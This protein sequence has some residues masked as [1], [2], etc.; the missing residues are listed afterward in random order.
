METVSPSWLVLKTGKTNSLI[1]HRLGRNF[2][3]IYKSTKDNKLRQFLF[4]L[5]YRIIMT[6]E[7]LFKFRLL[8]DEECTLCFR[9]DSIE[10]AFL[11][12]TVTTAFYS[13][14]ISWFNQENDTDITLSNKLIP[15][16]DIPRLIHLTD[17]PR[18]RLHLFV[19]IL[20]E[21]FYTSKCLEK[22]PNTLYYNGKE[23]NA[24]FPKLKISPRSLFFLI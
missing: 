8:E 1:F 4:R 3:F 12:C 10:H 7:E 22:K 6:K 9:P 13:K 19:I 18:R 16:N 17:Y 24:L 15:F 20:K 5:L 11:D 14:A 23:R 2:S 21:Y